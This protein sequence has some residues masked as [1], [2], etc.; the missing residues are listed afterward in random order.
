MIKKIALVLLVFW[1][2]ALLLAAGGTSEEVPLRGIEEGTRLQ[3]LL[4]PGPYYTHRVEMGLFS[5]TVRPQVAIW[6]EDAQGNFLQTLFVTQAV[7]TQGFVAA[8]R[9]GRPEALPVWS[10]LNK[11]QA[12]AVT[13]PTTTQGSVVYGSDAVTGLAPGE[14]RVM[15]EINRSYDW[16]E[17]YTRDNSG[18][19]GQPSL[20]WQAPVLVGESP[21]TVEFQA[22]GTGSV[23]GSDGR[24]RPGMEGLD[25]AL[26]LF[27]HLEVS[28]VPQ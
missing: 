13:S 15:M 26:E 7:E 8:P 14:Y 16:N 10:H 11:P 24:I 17:T 2:S 21:V 18:I 20:I 6:L 23:D 28:Y 12:D 22:V 3:F 19:N 5:Y 1:G 27:S 4:E 25:T 9:E